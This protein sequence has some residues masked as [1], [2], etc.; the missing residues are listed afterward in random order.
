MKVVLLSTRRLRAH[1]VDT[2]RD[3]LGLDA[4]DVPQLTVVSWNPP[5]GRLRVAQHLVVGPVLSPSGRVRYAR[6]DPASI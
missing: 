3:E 4:S 1:M 6:V 5:I 2:V